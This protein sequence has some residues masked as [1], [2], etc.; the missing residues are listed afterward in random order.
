VVGVAGRLLK[1]KGK[2]ARRPFHSTAGTRSS[3]PRLNGQD[4]RSTLR[5]DALFDSERQSGRDARSTLQARRAVQFGKAKRARHI[6]Q[7]QCRRPFR[8]LRMHIG[9]RLTMRA[10]V[11]G[12]GRFF[13]MKE[14]KMR[15]VGPPP[16]LRRR[17]DRGTRHWW[18]S[19]GTG[20]GPG[21]CHGG[22][23]LEIATRMSLPRARVLRGEGPV[24]TCVS[25]KRT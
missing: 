25:A 21:W 1:T 12:W 3:I 8:F 24:N 20:S 13:E 17:R 2:R 4:A 9:L 18:V 6:R 7:A 5:T 19:F 14:E 11:V 22:T 15:A 10:G 23:M 16:I